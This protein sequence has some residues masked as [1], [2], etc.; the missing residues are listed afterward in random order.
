MIEAGNSDTERT[1]RSPRC[2]GA[3]G[4][5]Y[6]VGVV[7]LA[8]GIRTWL[9]LG[10]I[11]PV[12]VDGRSMAPA[13][14]PAHRLAA[15]PQCL[16]VVQLAAETPPEREIG[17]PW[18]GTTRLAIGRSLL[19]GDRLWIDRTA[20]LRHKPQRWMPVAVRCPDTGRLCIKR[21]LGLP[22]EQVALIDGDLWIDGRRHIKTLDQQREVRVPV[23]RE[24]SATHRYRPA[25]DSTW[26]WD[27]DHWQANGPASGWLECEPPRPVTD[28][29]WFDLASSRQL[30]V[31][32]DVMFAGR[33]VAGP[34]VELQIRVA[35]RR[36]GLLVL[37]DRESAIVWEL[38]AKGQ[39]VRRLETLRLK[40]LPVETLPVDT[41]WRRDD[42]LLEVSTFDG[43]LLLAWDGQTLVRR[44]LPGSWADEVEALE[45]EL[46]A[47]GGAIALW[48]ATFYRDLYHGPPP[49]GVDWHGGAPRWQLADDA[50]FVAGDHGAV[51]IDSR[52]WGPIPERLL[53]GAPRRFRE[54]V[55]AFPPEGGRPL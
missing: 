34:D 47:T 41:L 51:S 15:C 2:W 19:R 29:V 20:Y 7:L 14:L 26:H 33:V 25:A 49:P 30:H 17:C 45:V 42:G 36:G 38:D 10:W 32:R 43:E 23:A 24:T 8:L 50:Y 27:G 11:E 35:G 16:G 44:G 48:K 4:L 3:V 21:V 39:R 22:G 53:I 18:C 5:H 37:L 31:Q 46:A 40:T 6:G 54:R 12:Y 13:Y 9:A 1:M 28:A 55:I 52:V